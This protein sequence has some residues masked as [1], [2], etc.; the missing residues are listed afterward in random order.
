MIHVPVAL[1]YLDLDYKNN[2]FFKLHKIAVK[3]KTQTGPAPQSSYAETL[4]GD[5]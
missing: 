4:V 5:S 3:N 2:I 1:Y